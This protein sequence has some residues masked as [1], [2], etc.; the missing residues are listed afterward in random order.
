MLEP[1]EGRRAFFIARRFSARQ[2]RS[3]L[4]QQ[5]LAGADACALHY[6]VAKLEMIRRQHDD[7]RAVLEPSEFVA[8]AD[9]G[10]AWELDRPPALGVERDVEE[11]QA[12]ASHESR[13]HPH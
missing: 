12:D 10:I 8:L 9:A 5:R 13:G 2:L 6:V 11:M 4:S 1:R 3:R 7:G